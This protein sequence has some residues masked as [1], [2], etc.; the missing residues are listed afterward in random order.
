MFDSGNRVIIVEGDQARADING[1]GL[2]H[3]AV[4]DQRELGRAAAHIDVKDRFVLA[5]GK[6]HC[7]AAVRRQ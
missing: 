7:A 2:R 4:F 5:F 6:I 1:G 3:Y